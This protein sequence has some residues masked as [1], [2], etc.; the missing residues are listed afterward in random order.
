MPEETPTI[1]DKTRVYKER[2]FRRF[3]YYAEIASSSSIRDMAKLVG[4]D[5]DTIMEWEKTPEAIEAKERGIRKVID[6]MEKTGKHDWRMWETRGKFLGLSPVDRKDITSDDEKI[7]DLSTLN[8]E[9][10]ASLIDKLRS[11]P[12]N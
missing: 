9:Q 10:L 8:D 4:V 2:E 5:K 11:T 7:N 12:G 1:P 3:L 6:N